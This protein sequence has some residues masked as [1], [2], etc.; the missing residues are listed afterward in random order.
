MMLKTQLFKKWFKQKQTLW[1][2]FKI[3]IGFL[4]LLFMT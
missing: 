2:S 1:T 3:H 4:S